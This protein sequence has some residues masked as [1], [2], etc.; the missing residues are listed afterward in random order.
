PGDVVH[1]PGPVLVG[2]DRGTVA[3]LA[4]DLRVRW[5]DEESSA[6]H[7]LLFS[8]VVSPRAIRQTD[9]ASQSTR[10]SPMPS[11]PYMSSTYSI[12]SAR[13][14]VARAHLTTGVSRVSGLMP[15]SA[16]ICPT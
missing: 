10:Y 1:R 6:H 16:A 9:P 4:D 11:P 2:D 14:R 3:G 7:S 5:A 12:T 13:R 8:L 15:S